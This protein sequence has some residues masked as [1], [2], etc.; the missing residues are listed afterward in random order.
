[1]RRLAAGAA[2]AVAGALWA[3]PALADETITAGPVPNTFANPDVTIDQG[4]AVTFQ[5]SDPTG[6]FH[7]VTSD[8]N[9]ADGKPLFVSET[10]EGGKTASVKGVEFLTTGDY[11]YRCSVHQ[12]MTGTIHVSSSGTPKTP[13]PENPAPSSADG[14]PPK[15]S[16]TIL[17]S[18]I[19]DVLEHKGVRV[20]LKTNEP[21]RF[22]LTAKS[23]KTTVATGTVTVKGGK[24]TTKLALTKKGK[25]LLFKANSVKLKLS[26]QVNDAA[27]NRSGATATRTLR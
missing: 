6:A 8:K 15:A 4:E 13:T 20:R 23:G 5:N 27:D 21:S 11:P 26:A 14:T 9:G 10:I 1:V 2:L 7:D 19:S 17:D 18:R 3:A 16:V 25:Q 22:K 24:R 12:F